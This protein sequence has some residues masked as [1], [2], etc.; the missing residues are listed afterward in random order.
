MWVRISSSSGNAVHLQRQRD[1][2]RGPEVLERRGE[3]VVEPGRAD[4]VGEPPQLSD[5]DLELGDRGVD[6]GR[7]ADVEPA[8]Q[9]P[10][11][12]PGGHDPLLGPVVQVPFET[13]TLVGGD[14]D[15][16]GPAR[17]DVLEGDAELQAK[18]AHL[19]RDPR[20]RSEL[21]DEAPGAGGV[22]TESDPGDDPAARLEGEAAR[23]EDLTTRQVDP[24][25][26]RCCQ[27]HPQRGVTLRGPEHLLDLLGL[28]PP[29]A[30]VGRE[31]LH[32][33]HRHVPVAVH[34]AA[35]LQGEVAVQR[36]EDE[37][38]HDGSGHRAEPG[39]GLEAA[40][41]DQHDSAE[42]HRRAPEGEQ[43]A[44]RGAEQPV[45]VE[46]IVAHHR[47]PDCRRDQEHDR[48]QV[49]GVG[50]RQRGAEG[51]R[52]PSSDQGRGHHR[53]REPE[54]PHLEPHLLGAVAVADRHRGHGEQDAHGDGHQPQRHRD[55]ACGVVAARHHLAAAHLGPPQ[56]EDHGCGRGG[57]Q[58]RHGRPGQPATPAAREDQ[59]E[60]QQT[61][62]VQGP[63][64]DGEPVGR[65]RE[66][67]LPVGAPGRRRNVGELDQGDRSPGPPEG[68]AGRRGGLVPHDEPG[69]HDG[70]QAER[71]GPDQRGSSCDPDGEADGDDH[72]RE[73][74]RGAC[75][76]RSH[77]P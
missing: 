31:R 76:R 38:R 64:A 75:G 19:E 40:A 17:L 22:A 35:H 53:P 65:R 67:E 55:G 7:S 16:P 42:D 72:G 77:G 48:D 10:Q 54:P 49:G 26:A 25:G 57:V 28:P 50:H 56:A 71:P 70:D 8:L 6:L 12:H 68:G 66:R 41:D 60:R 44:D 11:P 14:R 1:R 46:E 36:Q 15:Q 74:G 4:A 13:A 73:R 43:P 3:A 2:A 69:D 9:A 62:E 29:R 63:Q 21:G 5:S 61:G 30:D 39:P 23:V 58:P 47:D 27:R 20:R 45:D 34:D 51:L 33:R 37:G 32:R 18:A 52:D 59:Q 24:A